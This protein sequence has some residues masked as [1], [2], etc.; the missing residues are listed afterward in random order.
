MP[1][2][3]FCGHPL[4]G[5][6]TRVLEL[7]AFL[8]AQIA[9]QQLPFKVVLVQ[10][11]APTTLQGEKISNQ[12]VISG[13]S[14]VLSPTTIV[15]VDNTN[16]VKGLRYQLFCIAKNA[17]TT[18]C[19]VYCGINPAE[20]VER[21]KR[22]K[23]YADEV[24]ADYL[25][26]FEEPD[27]NKRWDSPLFTMIPDDCAL[28][29]AKS[30]QA[31]QILA[32]VLS[33]PLSAN[34]ST[35]NKPLADSSCVNDMSVIVGAIVQACTTAQANGRM[36]LVAVPHSDAKVQLPSRPVLASQWARIKRDYQKMNAHAL[37][38]MDT[39]A[40]GFVAFINS[41]LE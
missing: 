37:Q 15:L 23:R 31:G 22:L 25:G 1:L 18:S 7:Q 32:A 5:K 19:V 14:A 41:R 35:L 16:H 8:N 28:T 13:A 3:T 24:L 33:R 10:P 38:S 4:S 21:N 30:R 11:N 40:D 17:G 34:T 2:I 9:A 39:L 29:D 27:G 20:C 26:R 6:S 36:G 12:Q